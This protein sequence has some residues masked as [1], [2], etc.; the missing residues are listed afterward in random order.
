MKKSILLISVLFIFLFFKVQAEDELVSIFYLDQN[1]FEV[2]GRYFYLGQHSLPYSMKEGDLFVLSNE[3]I[4][5]IDDENY[6]VNITL[7]SLNNNKSFNFKSIQMSDTNRSRIKHI[8]S[9]EVNIKKGTYTT[10]RRCNFDQTCYDTHP[11]W[12]V[13]G[14]YTIQIENG[15][16]YTLLIRKREYNAENAENTKKNYLSACIGDEIFWGN[17]YVPI[18]DYHDHDILHCNFNSKLYRDNKEIVFD[19]VTLTGQKRKLKLHFVKDYL[20]YD[21]AFSKRL[22]F[23]LKDNFFYFDNNAFPIQFG[24]GYVIASEEKEIIDGKRYY[25]ILG[26]VCPTTGKIRYFKSITK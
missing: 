23:Y 9:Q 4:I 12:D 17:E 18:K 10:S 24:K 8:T 16:Y 3:E 13:I 22:T 6:F 14:K 21:E 1:F 11:C 26:I 15:L 20:R 2:K 25:T 5:S 7:T 19:Q